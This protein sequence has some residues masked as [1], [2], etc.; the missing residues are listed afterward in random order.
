MRE[1]ERKLARKKLDVEMWP[2]RKAARA[3]DPTNDLLRAVRQT[4]GIPIAE[5]TEK[6]G[7]GRSAVS[8]LEMRERRKTITLRSL[9]RMAG[10][11]GCRVV[12][13][14]VPADGGTLE[15]MAEERLWKSLLESHAAEM[16]ERGTSES[17]GQ[18]VSELASQRVSEPAGQQASGLA[19]EDDESSSVV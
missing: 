3:K 16:E 17:A 9:A 18:R 15:H 2:F 5:I 7:V 8:D 13:G 4:L 6:M 19:G 1:K 11:M 10:A 12:Y 14:V